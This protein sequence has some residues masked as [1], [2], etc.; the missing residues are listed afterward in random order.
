MVIKN[1]FFMLWVAIF[2][3]NAFWN[4][5]VMLNVIPQI[6]QYTVPTMLPDIEDKMVDFFLDLKT[7][8]L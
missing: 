4:T 6:R 1:T 8:S 5:Y 3:Y 7:N 2:F